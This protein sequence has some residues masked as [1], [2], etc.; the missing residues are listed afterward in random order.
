MNT[1]ELVVNFLS[2]KV[3]SLNKEGLSV[4]TLSENPLICEIQYARS[5]IIGLFQSKMTVLQLRFTFT[6]DHKITLV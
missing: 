2:A 4:V 3:I 1:Q 6:Q 5:G